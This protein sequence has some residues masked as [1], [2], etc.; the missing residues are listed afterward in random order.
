MKTYTCQ[1]DNTHTK[2]EEIP[3]LGHDAKWITIKEATRTEDGLRQKI[4]SRCSAVLEE[5][6]IPMVV[7]NWQYNSVICCEGIPLRDVNPA[8]TPNWY[9]F[10]P[11]DLSQDG[12][13]EVNLVIGNSRYA[14]TVTV[15]VKNGKA[16]FDVRLNPF[17][18]KRDITFTVLTSLDLLLDAEM[19]RQ[20]TFAFGQEISIEEELNGSTNVLLY[21]FGHGDYDAMENLMDWFLPDSASYQQTVKHLKNMME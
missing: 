13:Q 16:V 5:E 20:D 9:M 14:G 7:E 12:V 10:T 6:A 8:L 4:C 18:Q 15:T 19:K 11:V 2:T 17:V 1:N 3:A 21:V